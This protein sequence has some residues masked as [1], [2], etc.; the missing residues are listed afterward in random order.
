MRC[1]VRC[2]FR[3][4]LLLR[5]IA[6]KGFEASRPIVKRWV[7]GSGG[8]DWLVELGHLIPACCEALAP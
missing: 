8:D 5:S 2:D 7:L 1:C 3:K 6:V 4:H